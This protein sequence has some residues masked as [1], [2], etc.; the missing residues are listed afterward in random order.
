MAYEVA[1]AL[2]APLDVV[3]VRKLGLPWQPELAMG[4]IGEDG[5][6]LLDRAMLSRTGV[7]PEQL[8]SIESAERTRLSGQVAR[9]RGGRA[10]S[11]LEGRCAVIVD[12]GLATGATAR[13]ACAIASRRGAARVVLAVPVGPPETVASFDAADEVVC[14]ETPRVF[15]AVGYHYLDFAQVSD[16]EVVR[17]L[18]P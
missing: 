10:P 7:T 13:L 6:E 16:A 15:T 3:V 4:A 5:A 1:R 2:G 9:F 12:D 17:L 8:A 18:R 14:L 11:A